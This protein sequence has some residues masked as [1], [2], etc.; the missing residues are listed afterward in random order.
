MSSSD[1]STSFTPSTCSFLIAY[2]Q[3]HRWC[4]CWICFLGKRRLATVPTLRRYADNQPYVILTTLPPLR[5]YD[6]NPPY[7]ILTPTLLTSL[8][9]IIIQLYLD[10]HS[11]NI[12]SYTSANT[13][14]QPVDQA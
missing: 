8:E 4:D 7:I 5:W 1:V 13:P 9:H 12:I 3:Q 6:N 11:H 10:L 14:S 2:P